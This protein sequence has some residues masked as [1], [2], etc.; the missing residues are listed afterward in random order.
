MYLFQRIGVVRLYSKPNSCEQTFNFYL[1]GYK[2]CDSF[3]IAQ[4]SSVWK[5]L[6]SFLMG[7][8]A[9]LRDGG[10][11]GAEYYKGKLPSIFIN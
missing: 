7:G 2:V 4:H 5:M 8:S 3:F 6:V 9:L 11:K 1:F 10:A